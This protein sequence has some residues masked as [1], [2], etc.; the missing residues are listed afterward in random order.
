LNKKFLKNLNYF[1]ETDENIVFLFENSYNKIVDAF[2]K[3]S[4]N[5]TKSDILPNSKIFD[6]HLLLPANTSKK[7]IIEISSL[8]ESSATDI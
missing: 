4:Y 5:E 3:F 6:Y 2:L 7:M 8:F 1:K